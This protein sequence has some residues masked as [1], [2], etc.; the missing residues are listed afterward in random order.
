MPFG[1]V[2]N[3]DNLAELRHPIV[4][5]VLFVSHKGWVMASHFVICIAS[6]ETRSFNLLRP[7][8]REALDE[9]YL[10]PET[11]LRVG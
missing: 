11:Y 6:D 10:G 8:I 3:T 7:D 4:K 1:G 2:L 9:T 5:I